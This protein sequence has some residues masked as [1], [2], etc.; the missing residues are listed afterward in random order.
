MQQNQQQDKLQG[1]RRTMLLLAWVFAL[2][3]VTYLFQGMLDRFYNPNQQFE[4]SLNSDGSKEVRLLRNRQGHYVA[5]GKINGQTVTFLLD[6]GATHVAIPDRLA[7]ELGLSRL[8]QA[9]SRTAA[10]VVP[11]W[12]TRLQ[13]VQLGPIQMGDVA[14]TIVPSMP[15]QVEVLLG[16]SFLQHLELLQRGNVLTLRQR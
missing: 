6:T 14:A 8:Q 16:M 3:F 1:I 7:R 10:G 15:D 13:S 11:V 5:T 12:R 2:G 9:R 4:S